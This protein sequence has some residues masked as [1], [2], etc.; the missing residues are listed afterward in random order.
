MEG[1]AELK[2]PP[3]KAKVLEKPVEAEKPKEKP[4]FKAMVVCGQGP[5]KPV[6]LASE[7]TDSQKAQWETFKKDPLHSTEPRFR[8]MEGESYLKELN[9]I[10]ARTDISEDDKLK[11]IEA[12][13]QK[14]QHT[15]RFALNRWSRENALAA[16]ALLVEGRTDKLIL[17]GGKTKPNFVGEGFNPLPTERTDDANWPSEAELMR[18]I[19]VSRFR[20]ELCAKFKIPGPLSPDY[21]PQSLAK[22]LDPIIKVEDAS[23]NTL[24][25][26][27]YTIN[28]SPDLLRNDG[29]V[30]LLG[31]DFHIKRVAALSHLFSVNEGEGGQFGAQEVLAERAGN[32]GKTLYESIL[33]H[34]TTPDQN[35]DLQERMH[36]EQWWTKK[37]D[38]TLL[39]WV[40]YFGHVKDPSVLQNVMALL[41]NDVWVT[42]AKKAFDIVGL[43]F[44]DLQA[45]D[46]TKMAQERPAV[47]DALREAIV[48][49]AGNGVREV[50]KMPEFI[51]KT[52]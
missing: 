4:V 23:T 20:S 48:K 45:Q 35:V 38:D 30:G 13:R 47:Y 33:K 39:Y 9:A 7:L 41:K 3:I 18:E 16:G 50:P 5:V 29:S 26:F 25:N 24:E 17:S 21:D 42:Q 46:F 40:G 36:Q 28:N 44:D 43:N 49:L 51:P 8:V 52:T 32:Q 15:G 27:A 34:M 31:T 14:W 11:Q 22:I 19:I 6:L 10:Q 2:Q 37:L 1:G 12:Q